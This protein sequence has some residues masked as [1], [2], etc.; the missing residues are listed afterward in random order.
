MVAKHPPLDDLQLCNT[1][2]SA[3]LEIHS[4]ALSRG[5]FYPSWKL[6]CPAELSMAM[7]PGGSRGPTGVLLSGW[8]Q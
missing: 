6:L 7:I 8:Y 5:T 4:R 3:Y 2:R 1:V